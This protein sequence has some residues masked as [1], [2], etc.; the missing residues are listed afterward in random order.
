[1]CR[2]GASAI[3]IHCRIGSLETTA[4]AMQITLTIHCRIGSLE[5]G[6]GCGRRDVGIH[7]RIGSLEIRRA[8]R[9]QPD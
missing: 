4:G 2:G 1:M 6:G 9:A 8:H 3:D 7:C 5:M